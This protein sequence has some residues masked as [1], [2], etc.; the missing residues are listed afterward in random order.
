MSTTATFGFAFTEEVLKVAVAGTAGARV[1]LRVGLDVALCG[2]RETALTAG[3]DVEVDLVVGRG[4]E[5]IRDAL[6]SLGAAMEVCGLGG[7]RETVGG[8]VPSPV[9]LLSGRMV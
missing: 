4:S 8:C 1:D 5:P 3:L 2:T 6:E 9:V 7:G